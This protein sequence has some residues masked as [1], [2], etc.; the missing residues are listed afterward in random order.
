[1]DYGKEFTEAYI[2]GCY[3]YEMAIRLDETYT[4]AYPPLEIVPYERDT[5][6]RIDFIAGYV[7]TESGWFSVQ[8]YEQ[9]QDAKGETK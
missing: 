9:I 6:E 2:L 4:P 3:T 8:E 7:D 1:M 5:Q